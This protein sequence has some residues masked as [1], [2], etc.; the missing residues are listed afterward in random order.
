M[1]CSVW[2]KLGYREER[3]CQELGY[4]ECSGISDSIRGSEESGK[5]FQ[6]EG[7]AGAKAR[8]NKKQFIMPGN[9]NR[10]GE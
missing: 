9:G 5:G 3:S 4:Q 6:P 7:T 8:R 2:R 10:A 1:L